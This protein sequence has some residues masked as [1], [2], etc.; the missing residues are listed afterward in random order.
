MA[1]VSRAAGLNGA[2]AAPRPP[3][4]PARPARP[5][6]PSGADAGGGGAGAASAASTGARSASV[7]HR[8]RSI[9]NAPPAADATLACRF[10]AG[11]SAE[12]SDTARTAAANALLAITIVGP[13]DAPEP[14]DEAL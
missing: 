9:V 6:A 2:G 7:D 3:A 14:L 10:N 11:S 8:N 1:A 13:F 5:A 12:T 4:R